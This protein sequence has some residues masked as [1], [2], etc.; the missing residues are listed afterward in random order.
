MKKLTASIFTV[1]LATVGA[2]NAEIASKAY[3]DQRDD[4][5]KTIV[6][7]L[8][9]LN[10]TTKASV[11]A[12]INSINTNVGNLGTMASQSTNDYYTKTAADAQFVE[13]GT[14]I[15]A[16]TA[17]SLVQYDAQGLVL[18][19]T[20]AGALAKKDT[21]ANADIAADAAIA[22][23]KLAT[24][25]QTSLGL[26]DTALQDD[27][28]ADML[29]K[30][31]AGTTYA[32]QS[33][34]TTGLSGK[35]DTLTTDQQNA[36]DSGITSALVTK[37]GTNESAIATLN[38]DASTTGSVAKAI[39]DANTATT[40]ALA[41]KADK[42]TTLAGYGI[43]DAYTK[44]EVDTELAKKQNNLG[45][46]SDAGKVVT[47]T[48][49][50]GTVAYTAIDSAPTANSTN[51][52]T[53]GG[54]KSALDT[55]ASNVTALTTRMDTAESDID[56]LESG[57]QDKLTATNV[58]TSGTGNAVTAVTAADGSVSVTLG[59]KFIEETASITTNGK[60]ALTANITDGAVSGYGWELIQRAE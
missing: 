7:A 53:S 21:V 50:A 46:A 43:T 31:E 8:D 37:I 48:A 54:V 52:I 34:L 39:A 49:T 32:T 36:V 2:A 28:I 38:G 9:D 59:S 51:L 6:G 26:A 47:A 40:A 5:V 12:A 25:V 41:N 30:T 57:K 33:A 56:T 58:T 20:P 60:Y 22:K 29:T 24:D 18:S 44:G 1:L 3:V 42:A 23:T 13:A 11:V 14:A 19:G 27:D 16:S 4:A 55:A 35:Q 10:T 15:T 45:G 17:D